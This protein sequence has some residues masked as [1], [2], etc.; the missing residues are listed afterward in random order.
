VVLRIGPSFSNIQVLHC[1][2][3]AFTVAPFGIV[4]QS[5]IESSEL[6]QW[7]RNDDSIKRIY[8][9]HTSKLVLFSVVSVW[10]LFVCL[11]VCLSTR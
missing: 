2:G 9:T 3:P 1:P 5:L 10:V 11:S 8:S 4:L 7:M 6:V